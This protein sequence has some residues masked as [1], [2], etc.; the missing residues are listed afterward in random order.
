MLSQTQTL[1]AAASSARIAPALAA[2]LLGLALFLTAGFAGATVL[3]N[4]THDTRHAFG[5]P[6]H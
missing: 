3:H 1:S 4:S 5:L 6:C 2:L